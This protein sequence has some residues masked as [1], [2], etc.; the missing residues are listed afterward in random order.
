MVT[1]CI[2]APSLSA[3]L[4]EQLIFWRKSCLHLMSSPGFKP[5]RVLAVF[6]K[7]GWRHQ[8]GQGISRP[9]FENQSSLY[10]CTYGGFICSV[11]VCFYNR[12]SRASRE[13]LMSWVFSSELKK[14]SAIWLFAWWWSQTLP[15]DTRLGLTHLFQLF[16]WQPKG[17]SFCEVETK[18]INW[19]ESN[20]HY[21]NG[22]NEKNEEQQII[23]E[24]T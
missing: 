13:R 17:I 2:S 24:R 23:V 9:K 1:F 7:Y 15:L 11:A 10:Y 16:I 18:G 22:G 12:G 6:P 5:L 14:H 19:P 20:L 8:L 4:A 21:A 3:Y